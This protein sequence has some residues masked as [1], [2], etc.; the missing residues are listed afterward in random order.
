M[1]DS[2]YIIQTKSGL[3]DQQDVEKFRIAHAETQNEIN[4]QKEEQKLLSGAA[5]EEDPYNATVNAITANQTQEYFAIATDK[6]FE[7]IQNDSGSSKLKKKVQLC[8]AVSLVEMMYK[9]NIIVLVFEQQ[10]NK[11]V[12]WDDHEKK[13]RTEITFNKNQIINNV[14][15]RKDMMVVVLNEKAFIF[16]FV[17][18]KLIEQVETFPNPLGLVALSQAEKPAS[19]INCLPSLE[20]GHLKVLNFVVDKSIDL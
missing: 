4:R 11:V 6:G 8:K 19:K 17:S 3:I 15:L 14:K 5:N 9:T 16:N 1:Q 13:K 10:R 18:L 12:I 7:I 2:N 20:K